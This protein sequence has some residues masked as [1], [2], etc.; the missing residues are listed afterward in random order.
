M[1]GTVAHAGFPHREGQR[2]CLHP[3]G[4]PLFCSQPCQQP[5]EGRWRPSPP[6]PG[7]RLQRYAQTV[8]G[9]QRY[10]RQG[11]EGRCSRGFH[12]Q[13][14]T[15][16]GRPDAGS[17][18]A[19]PEPAAGWGVSRVN[20]GEDRPPSLLPAQTPVAPCLAETATSGG[21]PV[22]LPPRPSPASHV[23]TVPGPPVSCVWGLPSLTSLILVRAPSCPPIHPHLT[24]TPCP[25]A[26]CPPCS[27]GGLLCG[28]C[29]LEDPQPSPLCRVQIELGVF[30]GP[31]RPHQG[32]WLPPRLGAPPVACG[33]RG[34]FFFFF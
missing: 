12:K 26:P 23:P 21:R 1:G 28:W 6:T 34:C 4:H 19:W 11:R 32:W 17:L 18:T 31:P 10:P 3:E 13:T 8:W 24:S 20:R 22:P 33:A 25:S 2:L 9:T 30:P 29:V 5:R 27:I 14:D 7:H 15:G 16:P